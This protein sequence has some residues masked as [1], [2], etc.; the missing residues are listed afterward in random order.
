M[1]NNIVRRQVTST[2][3]KILQAFS[4]GHR[5][6][7]MPLQGRVVRLKPVDRQLQLMGA[8]VRELVVEVSR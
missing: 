1:D 6:T 7:L 3:V 5:Q 8:V 4:A 2:E